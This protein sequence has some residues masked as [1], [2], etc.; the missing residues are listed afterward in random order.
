M[1]PSLVTLLLGLL[2]PQNPVPA[3]FRPEPAPEVE[4]AA[5]A[6][7]RPAEAAVAPS[8]LLRKEFFALRTRPEGSPDAIVALR[9]YLRGGVEVLEEDTLFADGSLATSLH[10]EQES[11]GTRLIWREWNLGLGASHS[12]VVD[13]VGGGGALSIARYGLRSKTHRRLEDDPA[14][15]SDCGALL[16]AIE[17]TRGETDQNT[18]P[19]AQVC[20]VPTAQAETLVTLSAEPGRWG[21]IQNLIPGSGTPRYV[22]LIGSTSRTSRECLWLGNDLMAMRWRTHSAWAGSLAESDWQKQE[23]TWLALARPRVPDAHTRAMQASA[24][25]LDKR[26]HTR[27]VWYQIE[28]TDLPTPNFGQGD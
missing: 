6:A 10:E 13:G 15:R 11:A 25:F 7:T 8:V 4:S 26:V 12:V 27:P 21:D 18:A 28:G 9:H 5:P 19:A 22:R 2:A 20:L 17:R 3:V 23:Q 1:L 24:P 16:G 14:G